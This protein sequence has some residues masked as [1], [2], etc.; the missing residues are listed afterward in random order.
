MARWARWL[1][2]LLLLVPTVATAQGRGLYIETDCTLITGP[3]TGKTWCFDATNLSLKVW[4]GTTMTLA[5][6]SSTF[7]NS[8]FTGT[9]TFGGTFVGSPHWST[10]QVFPSLT[11]GGSLP[12]VQQTGDLTLQCERSPVFA[13]GFGFMTLR[14][15]PGTQPGTMKLI[16]IVGSAKVETV[17]MDNIP[18]GGC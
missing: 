11:I 6:L 4:N 16:A 9:T 13:P 18:G 8:T 1:W 2:L 7:N 14:V 12:P 10:P 3:V 17:V 5:N 15:R